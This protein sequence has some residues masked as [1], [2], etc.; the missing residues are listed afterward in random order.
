MTA[1]IL[2]YDNLINSTTGEGWNYN[3]RMEPSTIAVTAE[4]LESKGEYFKIEYQV[5]FQPWNCNYNNVHSSFHHVLESCF[6]WIDPGENSFVRKNVVEIKKA[7]Y[8]YP[9]EIRNAYNYFTNCSHISI[10]DK[11]RQ[12]VLDGF[13]T[14]VMVYPFEGDLPV[15]CLQ[16]L[17]ILIEKLN[18]PAERIFL[19]DG[20][21]D[22]TAFI[23]QP[24]KH[25]PVNVFPSWLKEFTRDDIITYIPD[26]LYN[27]YN[28]RISV[29][30]I[31]II[32]LLN[33]KNLFQKGINSFGRQ[34]LEGVIKQTIDKTGFKFTDEDISFVNSIRGLSPDNKNLNIG[35]LNADN[36]AI[37]IVNDHY[38]RT[39]VSLVNETLSETIFFSEKIYKPICVGHPFLLM[40]GRNQLKKLKD[41]GFQTFEKWWSEKYDNLT[42]QLE[43]ANAIVEILSYL[44]QKSNNELITIRE[45]M[46]ET[47]THNQ[48]VFNDINKSYTWAGM[49]PVLGIMKNILENKIS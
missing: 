3:G 46:K 47:L 25:V 39:F 44:D 6:S 8:I 12:D 35:S 21:Y 19:I 49:T 7:K 4:Y 11:V 29:H 37:H 24:Y 36:P 23:G 42:T 40:G 17:K 16:K 45:E 13:A 10:S 2:G 15:F 14:I 34:N 31:L 5:L 20:N 18:L 22:D 26:K 48:K 1:I 9:I 32:T 33:R 27:C 43:R 28:R 41:L 30:R 38:Q